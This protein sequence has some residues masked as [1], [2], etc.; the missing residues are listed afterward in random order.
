[1]NKINNKRY[2]LTEMKIEN[3]LIK[4]LKAKDFDSVYIND[5][6]KEAGISRTSFYS[7]YDDINDLILKI[8]N[9]HY[10][11]IIHILLKKKLSSKDAFTRYFY[12]LRCHSDFYKAYLMSSDSNILIGH[13]YNSIFDLYPEL[14]QKENKTERETKYHMVFIGAGIKAISRKWLLNGC[15]ETP[16]EMI[17]KNIVVQISNKNNTTFK[18]LNS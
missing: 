9:K 4:L 1:M 5:I 8:Q 16:E 3:A 18:K 2:K 7:H 15:I 10:N 12:Y 11:N 14:I 6:C 13:A 17:F